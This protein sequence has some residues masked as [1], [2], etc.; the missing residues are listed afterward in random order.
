MIIETTVEFSREE[1]NE[2]M[3]GLY[4]EKVGKAPDGYHLTAEPYY[5]DKWR[6][7]IERD[8]EPE[9]KEKTTDGN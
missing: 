6:V 8:V 2:A 4:H 7:K 9:I 1:I 5:S 3:K